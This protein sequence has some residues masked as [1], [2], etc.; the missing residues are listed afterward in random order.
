M[1]LN[2]LEIIDEKFSEDYSSINDEDSESE[3]LC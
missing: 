3:D 2:E 1:E